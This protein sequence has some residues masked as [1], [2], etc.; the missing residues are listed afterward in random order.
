VHHRHFERV[1]G[2]KEE[3]LMAM[4]RLHLDRHVRRFHFNPRDGQRSMYRKYKSR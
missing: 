1:D 4:G 3:T 2:A